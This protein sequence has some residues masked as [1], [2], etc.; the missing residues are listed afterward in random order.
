M[1]QPR[2]ERRRDER[3]PQGDDAG[4]LSCREADCR[5]RVIQLIDDTILAVRP[6]AGMKCSHKM[7]YQDVFLCTS[8]ARKEIYKRSRA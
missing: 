6:P 1:D 5:C 3:N 7:R 8:A 4:S 2:V